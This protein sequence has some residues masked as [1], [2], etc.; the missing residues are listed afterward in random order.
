MK[1]VVSVSL[2]SVSRDAEGVLHLLGEDIHV[3]RIGTNGDVARAKAL[4]EELDGK[5]DCLG[6]GGAVLVFDAL[7]RSY[8]FSAVARMVAHVRHTPVVDGTGFKSVVERGVGA[9]V[10]Q[11][12]SGLLPNERVLI[13]SAVDRL[14]LAKGFA[15]NGFE[16]LM[17]DLGF[18]LGL[19]I[20]IR[21]LRGLNRMAH[22][23]GPVV[24]HLPMS[25]LYPSGEHEDVNRPRFQGWFAGCGVIA[26]DGNYITHSM[27]LDMAGKIVATNTTTARD[28]A[29]Y[30]ER[31]VRCVVTSTPRLGERTFGTNVM[32]AAMVALSGQGRKLAPDEMA[33]LIER[34]G[35]EP[36]I[37]MLG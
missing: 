1:R 27:P 26:G 32:E 18:A 29:L 6:V 13:T 25:A 19:P 3:Q 33:A 24:R 2:G 28:M 8:T 34:A 11:Q 17:G 23:I 21:T 22:T 35:L 30:R 4:Y 37:E 9:L 16:L 5:V 36:Q 14:A 15:E 31:G 10:R 12:L 20:A 7:D